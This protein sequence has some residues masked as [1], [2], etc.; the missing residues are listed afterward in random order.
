MEAGKLRGGEKVKGEKVGRYGRRKWEC[1][2]GNDRN[3]EVGPV[4]VP[5]ERDYAAA[6]DAEGGINSSTK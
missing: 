4:V 5:N 2:R 6:K 1:G 3:S